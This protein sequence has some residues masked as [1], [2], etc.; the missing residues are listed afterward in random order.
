MAMMIERTLSL[1][2]PNRRW[3]IFGPP[4]LVAIA[5]DMINAN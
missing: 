2:A 4:P 5:S 1:K 3:R